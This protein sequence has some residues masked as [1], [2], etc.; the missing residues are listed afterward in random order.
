MV[1]PIIVLFLIKA[2]LGLKKAKKN[3]R[4]CGSFSPTREQRAQLKRKKASNSFVSGTDLDGI[5]EEQQQNQPPK[6]KSKR[7]PTSEPVVVTEQDRE[8][9]AIILDEDQESLGSKECEDGGLPEA[10]DADGGFSEFEHQIRSAPRQGRGSDDE[11]SEAEGAAGGGS[12]R[13]STASSS[14]PSTLDDD[15]IERLT[16]RNEKLSRKLT[17]RENKIVKL[18][19]ALD[20]ANAKL[21][22]AAAERSRSS[23]PAGAPRVSP[24]GRRDGGRSTAEPPKRA[25]NRTRGKAYPLSTNGYELPP[26]CINNERL[27]D[28]ESFG[29]WIMPILFTDQQLK[30]CSLYGRQ[31]A[32]NSVNVKPALPED[33][34][35]AAL[36]EN[37]RRFSRVAHFER[38]FGDGARDALPKSRKRSHNES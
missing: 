24:Q 35:N 28:P 22:A 4:D 36:N 20:E 6:K 14:L 33:I 21:A 11:L 9:A 29:K 2:W 5:L 23:P 3:F 15:L 7:N 31:M 26:Y 37:W 13:S 17:R 12:F 32:S 8:L 34:V 30:T 18:E 38:R 25:M 16:S 10:V 19:R 1:L 27:G